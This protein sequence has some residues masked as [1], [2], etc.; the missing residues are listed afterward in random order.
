MSIE[1][2]EL[3]GILRKGRSTCE[4]TRN[5]DETQGALQSETHGILVVEC[6]EK[7]IERAQKFWRLYGVINMMDG[8][9][10]WKLTVIT[11]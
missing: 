10:Y 1:I 3:T 6:T 4:P 11:Q 9:T 8:Q 2:G 7:A 5:R